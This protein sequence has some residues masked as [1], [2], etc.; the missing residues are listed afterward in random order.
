MSQFFVATTSGNL[1]PDVPT[2]FTSDNGMA[3]PSSNVIDVRGIDVTDNNLNGIQVE[4]GLA[5]TGASN[6]LQ[7]QITNR[8]TGNGQTTDDV[9]PV[10]IYTFPMGATPG[11]YLFSTRVVAY[12][13]TGS[14]SA[15]YV[16]FRVNRTTGVVG[17][18]IGA[19]TAFAT[20]EGAL[21]GVSI[22]NSVSSNDAV[23]T[24]TGVAGKTI[25]YIAVTEYVFVS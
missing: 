14:L 18:D 24:A 6:R 19:T 20:E 12:D 21:S 16:S 7:V 17:S 22:L 23:L 2:I 1:P 5:E 11:T 4:G 3:V 13:T 25:N 9:T 8:I 10:T 15:G